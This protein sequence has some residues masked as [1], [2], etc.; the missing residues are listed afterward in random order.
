MTTANIN[1]NMLIWARERSG[2]AVSEFARKCGVSQDKLSEWESGRRPLTF[3]QAMTYA[4]KAHIPFGYL[5]LTRPPIDELPIPDLRTVDG[6]ANR[7][8]SAELLDLIKLM[9]QRQEWYKDYLQQHFV[10]PNPIVGRFAVKDEVSSIVHDMRIALGVGNHPQRGSWEDYYRDL[11]NR[12]ESVGVLV[13]RQSDVGHYTRP[14]RVEEFRGF[15]IADDYAPII[16]VN[17]ADALG[18]RLFTLI[19]ELCH[20]WIGQSGISD[21]NT[22]THREEEILCNAVAAEFLVPASEFETLWQTDLE[23]WQANLP[24]LEAHFHVSTWTLARRALTLNFIALGEYQRYINAQQAA[25]RDR[26][27]S[28]G[29]GYYRTKKAQISQRFS[30]AVVSQ[31]L[32]GQLLLREAS[33]LLGGIKPNKIATFAKELG[34]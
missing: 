16:F 11:V 6:Q 13:M 26:E 27:D 1:T 15:A 32:C 30:R 4:E 34:V 19:H 20:I 21:A 7:K 33:Q 8:L 24:M 28:G 22:H 25:Y 17:H 14:L 10:G 18:A 2:I 23:S 29:P 3:K 9:Q 31:A 12:I 5:F